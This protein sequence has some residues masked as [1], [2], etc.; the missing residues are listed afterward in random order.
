MSCHPSWLTYA[1]NSHSRHLSGV[2]S[3]Y[4]SIGSIH[5]IIYLFAYLSNNLV[6]Y[7]PIYFLSTINIVSACEVKI[8]CTKK[9]FTMDISKTL[10]WNIYLCV[11][12]VRSN[13][14]LVYR[15]LLF[16]RISLY[17]LT[18]QLVYEL[19]MYSDVVAGGGLEMN[20]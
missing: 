13:I 20:N 4:L 19:I 3:I 18:I 10:K 14:Q 12:L 11:N 6:I 5:L 8:Y 1:C 7:L 16:P 17:L 15:L 9:F 2:L